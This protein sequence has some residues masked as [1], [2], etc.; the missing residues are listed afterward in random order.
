MTYK[1]QKRMCPKGY[2]S[3]LIPRSDKGGGGLA[4]AYKKDLNVI[5]CKSGKTNTM[6]YLAVTLKGIATKAAII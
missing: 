4:V 1:H 3:I 5:I 2:D 6:E